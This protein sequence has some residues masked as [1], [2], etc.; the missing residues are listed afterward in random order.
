MAKGRRPGAAWRQ[1]IGVRLGDA[2]HT[3]RGEGRLGHLR[4]R[5]VQHRRRAGKLTGAPDSSRYVQVR[6]GCGL[7]PSMDW[8]GLGGMTMTP[9]PRF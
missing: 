6:V 4:L 1:A 9:C 8:I 2:A 3:K 5:G 7:D